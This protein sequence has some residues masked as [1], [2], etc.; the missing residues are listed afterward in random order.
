MGGINI[1][2][3]KNDN[4]NKSNINNINCIDSNIGIDESINTK[5]NTKDHKLIRITYKGLIV[6]FLI[7]TLFLAFNIIFLEDNQ[8]NFHQI[9]NQV[10]NGFKSSGP[11]PPI[12]NMIIPANKEGHNFKAVNKVKAASKVSPDSKAKLSPFGS[13][14]SVSQSS[15]L[16]ASKNLKNYVNKHK[17][18]PNTVTVEGYKYSVPEFTYLMTK[19]VE[20]KKKKVSSRVDVKYN[21]KNPSKPS[22]KTIKTK[23]SSSNYYNYALK[24]TKYMNKHNKIPNYITGT[25]NTKIQYQTAVYMFSS[26]LYYNYYKKKL[27]SSISLS[28]STSHKMNKDVPNYV[29]TSKTKSV[30][31]KNSVWIQSKDFTK[32]NLDKLAES[33]IGN[34]FL[35]EATISKY[36][37]SKVI[38]WAKTAASKGIKTHLW[39]QCF[40]SNGEWVNPVDTTTKSYDQS[41][42]NK[43]LSKI[44]TYSKMDYIGG[45]HLDYLRYPGTAYKYSYSNGVTGE[46]AV[47]K[48]TSQAKNCIDKYNPNMLLSAAVMPETSSDAYYYGQNIPQ[49]G[50]YLDIIVPMAYKGNYNKDPSWITSTT[51]W[52]VKNSGGARIWT[53]I[54]TYESDNKPNALSNSALKVDCKAILNGGAEGIVLFRW[55]LT[56]FLTF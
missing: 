47:T 26:V 19:T 39:I 13:S 50:K 43:I 22:G 51:K 45:I 31:N 24:T 56:A 11:I 30:N 34:V 25:K 23:I 46:K 36:G 7:S 8:I 3:L 29:R 55:G 14:K 48:F 44:K 9:T 41:L 40:Y 16:S 12:L 2:D 21:I 4:D 27:P 6:I 28:V 1:F 33:G 49:L 17:K 42:F 53:G 37:K 54:Q 20:Y 18:L 52:F 10:S 32:V 38:S 35:H 5:I 15:V